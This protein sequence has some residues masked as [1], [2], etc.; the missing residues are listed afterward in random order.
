[1]PVSYIIKKNPTKVKQDI[2]MMTNLD[3]EIKTKQKNQNS[4]RN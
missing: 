3:I 4:I 1:M 2:N